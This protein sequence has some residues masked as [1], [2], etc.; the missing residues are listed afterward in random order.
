MAGTYEQ[1]KVGDTNASA[2]PKWVAQ[3]L[4]MNEL[5]NAENKLGNTIRWQTASVVATEETREN[6]AFGTLTTADEIK[7][8]V[9]PTSGII[10][11]Q[12][13]ALIKSSVAAAGRAAVFLGANQLKKTA[14][15]TPEVAEEATAGTG[16]TTFSASSSGLNNT[17]QGT[18]FVTTGQTIGGAGAY[19]FAAAGTYN[20]SIQYRATS[21]SITAKERKLWVG[22]MG[23]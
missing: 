8:V 10:F 23:V 17:L 5:L 15:T 13:A 3:F 2:G 21:G 14:T 12:F 7:S 19:I 18:S 9:L 20:I 11:L 16:F 22:V 4:G 6:V 1:A